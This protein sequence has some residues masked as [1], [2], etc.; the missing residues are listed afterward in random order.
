MTLSIIMPENKDTHHINTVHYDTQYNEIMHNDNIH[1]D[2]MHSDIQQNNKSN[3][4]HSLQ[5]NVVVQLRM[6][7]VFMLSMPPEN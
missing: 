5:L 1:N 2:N 7:I 3:T 6:F 4:E